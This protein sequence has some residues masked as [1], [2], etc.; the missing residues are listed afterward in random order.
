MTLT[1]GE[2][3][4]GKNYHIGVVEDINS[5]LVDVV[6][7]DGVWGSGSTQSFE[8]TNVPPG[9]YYL[10]VIIDWNGDDDYT[11]VYPDY[12][13]IYGWVFSGDE[14]PAEPN[15]TITSEDIS[16]DISDIQQ[17]PEE[18]GEGEDGTITVNLV[19][20]VGYVGDYLSIAVYE[21]VEPFDTV[22]GALDFI[23]ADGSAGSVAYVD[24]TA[25]PPLVEF[26]A[27]GGEYYHI[28]ARVIADGRSDYEI[29]IENV[30]IDGDMTFIVDF[31][32]MDEVVPEEGEDGTITV[33]LVNAGAQ[34]GKIFG[35]AVFEDDDFSGYVASGYDI[36]SAAGTAGGFAYEDP[37]AVPPVEFTAFGGDYYDIHVM[38]DMSDPPN[39]ITDNGDYVGMIEDVY[40]DGDTVVTADFTDMDVYLETPPVE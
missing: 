34:E 8:L 32:D 28:Y 7:F 25:E 23:I 2:D 30:L 22:A 38:V 14:P 4:A 15:L 19:N 16:A 29:M 12:A 37:E 5:A 31:N 1:N 36:I 11:D 33:N 35:F 17:I 40:I 13:G 10:Y 18:Y 21:G 6:S 3:G 24:P 20:A 26:I 39:G 27:T 9:D